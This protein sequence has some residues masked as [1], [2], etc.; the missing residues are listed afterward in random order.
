MTPEER[1]NEKYQLLEE[2]Y[3]LWGDEPNDEFDFGS[4]DGSIDPGDV[5]RWD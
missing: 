3:N 2:E 4:W 1:A 5:S